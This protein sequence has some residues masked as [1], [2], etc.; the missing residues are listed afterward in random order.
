M[1]EAVLSVDVS[2]SV[3][4]ALRLFTEY[5]VHHLPVVQ[6]RKLV[7][8][9]SS[10]DVMKLKNFLPK[11]ATSNEE[12]IDQRFRIETLM[13][14]PAVSVQ[15]HQSIEEAARLMVTHVVHALPVIDMQGHLIGIMTTT[16]M[17]QV[18]LHGAFPRGDEG[19]PPQD[20]KANGMNP[21][22]AALDATL[23]AARDGVLEECDPDSIASAMLYLERRVATLEEVLQ[24]V[25]RHFIERQ[26]E[27]AALE[28]ALKQAESLEG[29][30]TTAPREVAP[31]KVAPADR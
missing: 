17:M 6:E 31:L 13:S 27:I 30:K 18:L 23:E 25:R 7:G 28:K 21:G 10:A 9:L 8:M 14:H 29:P 15:S 5:P 26:D 11:N 1:T 16:D 2:A 24:L 19:G 4:E 22:I 3:S 12:Y 20:R